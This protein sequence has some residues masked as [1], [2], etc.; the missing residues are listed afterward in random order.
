ME[1]FIEQFSELFWEKAIQNIKCV[2]FRSTHQLLVFHFGETQGEMVELK[3]PVD[4]NADLTNPD[5]LRNLAEGKLVFEG[6]GPEIYTAVK[7]N[8]ADRNKE[9]FD[10]IEQGARPCPETFFY[11]LKALA[12]DN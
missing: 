8:I 2:E 6:N 5:Y 7:R 3:V 1:G 10:L 4:V 9:L 12:G 11:G